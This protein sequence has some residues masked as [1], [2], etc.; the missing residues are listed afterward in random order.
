M[1]AL[2]I[3][4]H[5]PNQAQNIAKILMEEQLID[6]YNF[7]KDVPS[8]RLVGGN[9]AMVNETILIA[10]TNHTLYTSIEKRLRDICAGQPMPVIYT[11]VD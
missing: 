6:G 9:I 11:T 3:E 5:Q 8:M 2:H 7:Y 10:T 4:T 1:A